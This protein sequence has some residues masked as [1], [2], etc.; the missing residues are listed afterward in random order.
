MTPHALPRQQLREPATLCW[1]TERMEAEPELS[2][3]RLA[4]EV[5]ARLE[6]HD[7]RGRPQEMA[8]RKQ[9]LELH[10]EGAIVLPPGRR[11]QPIPHPPAE[12]PAAPQIRGNL[13]ELGNV[14]LHPV[15]GGT[16]DSRRWHA[17]IAA[18]HPLGHARLC[19]AQIRYLIHS[20]RHGIIGALA[21]SAAAW[22]LNARDDWLAWTDADRAANLSRHRLQQPLPDPAIG[23]GEAP[24]LARAGPAHPPHRRR[25]AAGAT[26]SPPG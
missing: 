22:R 16:E 17:M 23:A 7:I 8:C 2:R 1:L 14:T 13:A 15:S 19:G 9:L 6:W 12:P 21:V 11:P 24:R 18:H 3:Y 5:C 20:K 25:L 10:R 26:A 4:K